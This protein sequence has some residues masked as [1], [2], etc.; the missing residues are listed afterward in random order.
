MRISKFAL[1][2]GIAVVASGAAEAD[3]PVPH[4]RVGLWESSMMMAGKPF[5]TQSC[6]SEESQA[7]MSVFSSQLRQ[8]NCKSSQVAHNMD[9]SWTSTSTCTFGGHERTSRAQ[10]TGDFNS[11]ITMVMY[12]NGSSTPDM[13]MT[14][15][16]MGPCKPG[17]KGG[18]VWMANGMKMNV[19][20]GTMSGM[21]K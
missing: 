10:L 17:M 16:W 19:I 12:T 14:M 8:K 5:T 15:T 18:D 9:G 11:K 21:P 7:K 1:L 3:T 6:V 2:A 4:Q 20:D 13:N